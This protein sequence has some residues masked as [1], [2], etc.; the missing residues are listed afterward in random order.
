MNRQRLYTLGALAIALLVGLWSFGHAGG[1][2][3]NPAFGGSPYLGPHMIRAGFDYGCGYGH[4]FCRWVEGI[5]RGIG[6]ITGNPY[7]PPYAD[8]A[9]LAE[10]KAV[11]TI[12]PAQEPDWQAY[13][14]TLQSCVMAVEQ[15][16]DS[17]PAA[18]WFYPHRMRYANIM[19]ANDEAQK[20]AP[21]IVAAAQSLF[22]KLS[23]EQQSKARYVL[24]GLPAGPSPFVGIE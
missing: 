10:L 8:P 18:S 2:M 5:E 12:T 21:I 16:H 24:P 3:F 19:M 14:S 7:L 23:Q 15:I 22:S 6:D 4:R 1:M 17:L 11:L 9:E 20:Q 13:Q